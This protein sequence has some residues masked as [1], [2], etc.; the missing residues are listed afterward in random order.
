M[1]KALK[2]SSY[3]KMEIFFFNEK[4]TVQYLYGK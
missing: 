3:F 2:L 1:Y 4:S